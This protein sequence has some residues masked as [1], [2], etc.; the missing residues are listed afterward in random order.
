MNL[1]IKVIVYIISMAVPMK[2][3][4][5]NSIKVIKSNRINLYWNCK[6]FIVL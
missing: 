1:F 4:G 6:K 3:G 5:M 2:N